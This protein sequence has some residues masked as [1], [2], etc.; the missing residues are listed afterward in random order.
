MPVLGVF[1][2]PFLVFL[3]LLSLLLI[4]LSA[5][6]LILNGADLSRVLQDFCSAM[7]ELRLTLRRLRVLGNFAILLRFA[8]VATAC[9]GALRVRRRE[10]RAGG[11]GSSFRELVMIVLLIL[12]L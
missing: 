3:M 11:V 5:P 7:D 8:L 2:R 12:R 9:L 10:E 1:L 6:R 4:L